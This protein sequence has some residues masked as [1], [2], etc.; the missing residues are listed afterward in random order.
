MS[1]GLRQTTG[2]VAKS[3]STVWLLD[4]DRSVLKA[5]GRLLASAGWEVERF[6]DPDAYLRHAEIHHPRV[7]VID[8]W[9]P[10]MAGFEVD[11]RPFYL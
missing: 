4:D 3:A 5:T 2:L 1:P 11:F 7:V 6:I 10:R 9:M 8:M